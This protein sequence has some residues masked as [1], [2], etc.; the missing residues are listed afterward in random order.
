MKANAAVS[1]QKQL[2]ITNNDFFNTYNS[3]ISL[4]APNGAIEEVIIT[5]NTLRDPLGPS[6]LPTVPYALGIAL[7][8]VTSAVINGNTIIGDFG[9]GVG[10]IHLEERCRCKNRR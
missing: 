1:V 6:A 5:G 7:A 9:T 8:S 10:A 2:K 3:A 4:N